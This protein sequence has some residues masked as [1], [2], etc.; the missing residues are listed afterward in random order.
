MHHT[1]DV[2]A[3][4]ERF[5]DLSVVPVVGRE[6]ERMRAQ[7][8]LRQEKSV[9]TRRRVLMNTLGMQ[10]FYKTLA[11]VREVK[12]LRESILKSCCSQDPV[13]DAGDKP[14]RQKTLSISKEKF[15]NLPRSARNILLNTNL[16]VALEQMEV[17]R[18]PKLP[19]DEL[20]MQ[21]NQNTM[22][23]KEWLSLSE[24]RE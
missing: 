16:V 21:A 22:A 9:A 8:T 24:T 3:V 5:R 10:K 7:K 15:E 14:W 12:R 13:A 23:Y 4:D 11:I 6:H 17:E 19:W 2:N 18:L 1:G 20:I